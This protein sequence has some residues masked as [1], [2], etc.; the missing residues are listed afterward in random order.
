M[1][2]LEVSHLRNLLKLKIKTIASLI[3]FSSNLVVSEFTLLSKVASQSN[4]DIG[5]RRVFTLLS[6]VASLPQCWATQI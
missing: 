1:A 3:D 6:K 4:T 5:E 2:E